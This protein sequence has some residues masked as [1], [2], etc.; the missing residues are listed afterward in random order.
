M[1]PAADIMVAYSTVPREESARISRA[2]LEQHL[3]ACI[4]V[5]PIRS[6]YW[7]KGKIC[8]DDEDLLVMKTRSARVENLIAELRS[9]HPYEVPE[10]VVLPVITG[11]PSYFDWV[12]RETRDSA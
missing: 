9:I 10:I 2:L 5:V 12:R 8:D 11:N 1:N 7:W 4:S 3:I 6:L